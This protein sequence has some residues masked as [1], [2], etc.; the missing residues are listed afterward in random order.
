MNR[1]V[2]A[3]NGYILKM[4]GHKP[5]YIDRFAPKIPRH[6]PMYSNVISETPF[7]KKESPKSTSLYEMGN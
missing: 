5:I 3:K 4:P 1:L 7:T 2:L 6:K